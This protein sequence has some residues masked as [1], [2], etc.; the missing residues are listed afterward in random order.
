[1]KFVSFWKVE[2]EPKGNEEGT[3]QR[4]QLICFR[5][6][7]ELNRVCYTKRIALFSHVI[8]VSYYCADSLNDFSLNLHLV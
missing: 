5:E 3:T 1:M 6:N 7:L 2:V 4:M 8:L